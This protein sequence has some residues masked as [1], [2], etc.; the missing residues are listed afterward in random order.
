MDA[1]IKKAV[2]IIVSTA[3]PEKVILFGSAAGNK[4]NKP[5][6]Y[7]ILILKNKIKK[8]RQMGRKIYMNFSNIGAPVD[9]IVEETSRYENLKNKPFYIYHDIAKSGRVI[10]EK[11]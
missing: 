6:D 2:D 1:P 4:K 11:N 3:D 10:Y 7:D 5:G 9:I 8:K